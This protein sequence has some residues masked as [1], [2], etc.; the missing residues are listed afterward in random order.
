MLVNPNNEYCLE[1]EVYDYY[2][3]LDKQCRNRVLRFCIIYCIIFISSFIAL[4]LF[5]GNVFINVFM[6]SLIIVFILVSKSIIFTETIS[7]ADFIFY[8]KEG[9]LSVK[10]VKHVTGTR[11]VYYLDDNEILFLKSDP[12]IKEIQPML[13]TTVRIYYDYK[14]CPIVIQSIVR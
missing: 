10:N 12:K 13:D 5:I 14:N 2:V 7:F 9:I 11:S 8:A 3:K 1:R 4:N 6:I